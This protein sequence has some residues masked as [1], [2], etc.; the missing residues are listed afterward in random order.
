MCA[1]HSTLGGDFKG[2]H[3]QTDEYS[4]ALTYKSWRIMSVF[5]SNF[6]KRFSFRRARHII[7]VSV[8]E[9]RFLGL[10]F[11]SFAAGLTL[12]GQLF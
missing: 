4:H 12:L 9:H 3:I 1:P 11:L 8:Y 2:M 5:R 10:I 6:K 7:A